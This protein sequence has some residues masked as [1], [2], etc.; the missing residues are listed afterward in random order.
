[1]R[2][3]G[4]VFDVDLKDPEKWAAAIR[5]LGYGTTY[6]PI[7]A[8]A[9]DATCRAYAEAAKRHDVII[10]E[11]GAWSNPISPDAAQA[12]QATEHCIRQ[13][14]LADRIGAACCVNIA[15]SRNA[16]QWDGPHPANLRRE[17][18]DMVV[19]SVRQII[20]AA[21]PTRTSYTLETMPWIFP[22][23]VDSY[24]QLIR[25]IDRKAFAVHLDPVNLVN[26]FAHAFDTRALLE[27]CFAR[28]G[29]WIK[30]CHAKD[31]RYSG[32]FTVHLDETLAGTGVL[33]YA[34]FV[35]LAE[36]LSPN[37]P[38]I[39]EHL[40]GAPEYQRA[41][42]HVRQIAHEQGVTLR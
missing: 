4:P 2:L 31:I 28:L 5:A 30:S 9:D 19:A 39:L 24:L 20:D 14:Q 33:D 27:D 40:P 6:C 41:A 35:T 1:M 16:Q 11:V 13:L 26:S 29:P 22:D 21:R 34:A 10:A 38:V 25:A 3:G 42:D 7:G 36:R 37:L 32:S 17:T 23:S 18:F 15:G 12:R 8:D